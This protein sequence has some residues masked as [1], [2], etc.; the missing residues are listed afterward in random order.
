MAKLRGLLPFLADYRRGSLQR[1]ERESKERELS[2]AQRYRSGQLQIAQDELRFRQEQAEAKRQMNEVLARQKILTQ[3]QGA[4]DIQGAIGAASNVYGASGLGGQVMPTPVSRPIQEFTPDYSFDPASLSMQPSQAVSQLEALGQYQGAPS[5]IQDPRGLV[6]PEE[7]LDPFA[8]TGYS[9]K[10]K[11]F[12]QSQVNIAKQQRR[13]NNIAY[14]D[15]ELERIVKGGKYSPAQF[16]KLRS[17]FKI[18]DDPTGA[19]EYIDRINMVEQKLKQ[20]KMGEKL[21]KLLS[22]ELPYAKISERLESLKKEYPESTANIDATARLYRDVE[23]VREVAREKKERNEVR[24]IY[25]NRVYSGEQSILKTMTDLASSVVSMEPQPLPELSEVDKVDVR[26][27]V[28][29][30]LVEKNKYN[31]IKLQ[32]LDTLY[33]GIDPNYAQFKA[34]FPNATIKEYELLMKELKGKK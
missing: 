18:S 10:K 29:R 11:Q 14:I 6:S 17:Q 9:P 30:G 32:E 3:A 26:K 22:E 27:K 4:G 5:P 16:D 24:D 12:I 8:G 15:K 34:E 23:N 7:A 33:A 25:V 31:P 28:I 20:G 21:T 2:E 13:Q 19:N 1:Q